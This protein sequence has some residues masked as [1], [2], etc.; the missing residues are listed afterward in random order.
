MKTMRQGK[1]TL[2]TL[3]E[4]FVYDPLVDWTIGNEWCYTGAFYGGNHPLAR[5]VASKQSRRELE[6]EVTVSMFSI[7]MAENKHEWIA[8]RWLFRASR[9]GSQYIFTAITNI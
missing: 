2:L 5:S 1:E 6:R 7:K 4:A 8:N 3:L 9:I